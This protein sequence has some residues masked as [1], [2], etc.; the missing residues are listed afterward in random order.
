MTTQHDK[1][2]SVSSWYVVSILAAAYAVNFLDRQVI[3]ILGQS[4]KTEL[5]ISDAQLGLLTGTAFG[6]FYSF[7]GIPIARF[8]DRAH[9]VNLITTALIVWSGLTALCGLTHTFAQLFLVRLGV[10]IGEAGGTPPSQSLVSDYVAPQR[11]IAAFSLFNLGLPVGSLLGF[12]L[13]GYV[14]QHFGWRIAFLAAGSPGLLIAVLLKFTVPEPARGAIEGEGAVG[15]DAATLWVTLQRLMSNKAYMQAIFGCS[16]A[17]FIIYV[18]NA[19]LPALFI[20]LHGF[21]QQRIGA[22]LALAVGLGGGIGI[23]GGGA[24]AALLRRKWSPYADLWLVA[25]SA[26]LACPTLIV[27]VWSDNLVFALSAMFFLYVFSYVWMGPTSSRVQDMVPIRS[28]AQAVGFMLFLSNIIGLACGP[29]L[30]GL[31]SDLLK[32]SYG[33]SSLRWA[34]SLA[35]VGSLVS[36]ACYGAA[37]RSIRRQNSCL[38]RND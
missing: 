3:N 4:I 6:L 10:G 24:L 12:L 34:L 32:P 16:F 36:A 27:A 38:V 31:I 30:V 28:R 7:L 11:R 37:A 19:W 8:A 1:A 15:R 9:R 35:S 29:P 26:V 17:I 13:G 5:G 20:R 23:M 25:L 18:T 14:S 33:P 21:S 22:W 2:S